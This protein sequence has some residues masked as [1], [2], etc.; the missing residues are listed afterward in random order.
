MENEC[1]DNVLEWLSWWNHLYDTTRWFHRK[2]PSASIMQ[3]S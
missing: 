2:G 1:Q 3:V